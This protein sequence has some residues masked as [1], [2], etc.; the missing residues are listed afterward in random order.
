MR[1]KLFIVAVVFFAAAAIFAVIWRLSDRYNAGVEFPAPA[2]SGANRA[3]GNGNPS[4]VPDT[5][6]N[7]VR[8]TS[9][10]ESGANPPQGGEVSI[11][12]DLRQYG[13]GQN[14]AINI[15]NNSD[16]SIF[17]TNYRFSDLRIW[18]IEKFAGGKWGNPESFDLPIVEKGKKIC[19]AILYERPVGFVDELKAGGSISSAWDQLICT[20]EGARKSLESGVYK[21]DFESIGPG[22]YRLSFRYGLGAVKTPDLENNPDKM[23]LTITAEKTAYSDEFE[24]K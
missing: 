23:P 2:Q 17:F 18:N 11:S 10:P 13:A 14:I 20:V 4:A 5:A 24:I 1:K 21:Y 12:A 9:S 3:A 15:K 6:Q 16:K 7:D 8:A 19:A 22:R